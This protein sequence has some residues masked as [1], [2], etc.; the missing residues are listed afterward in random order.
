MC[1]HCNALQC[2]DDESAL[3][4]GCVDVLNVCNGCL[5]V[6][7][8]PRLSIHGNGVHQVTLFVGTQVCMPSW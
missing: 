4:S 8:L 5:A 3:S 2:M 7:K 1:R 6:D